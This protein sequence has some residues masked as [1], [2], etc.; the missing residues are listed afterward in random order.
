MKRRQVPISWDDLEVA[1]ER[2]APNTESFLDLATGQVV[3]IVTGEPEA[4]IKRQQVAQDI[5]NYVRVEPASS[6]EQY[7]WMERFVSSVI[8][9]ALRER[10]VAHIRF[11][12]RVVFEALQDSMAEQDLADLGLEIDAALP[13]LCVRLGS[14]AADPRAPR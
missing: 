10:L 11:E 6:R 9:D 4:S 7:R 1:V 3:T 8:D 14:A 13:R 2:N 12:E 5:E